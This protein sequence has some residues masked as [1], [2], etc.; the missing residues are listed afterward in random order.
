MALNII[1]SINISKKKSFS[2]FFQ[3]ANEGFLFIIID[4]LDFLRKCLIFNPL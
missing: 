4:G 1:N 2:N 3:K